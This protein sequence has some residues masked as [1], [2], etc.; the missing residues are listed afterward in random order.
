M[1]VRSILSL[2][3][4]AV[5]AVMGTPVANNGNTKSVG[6]GSD[7]TVTVTA[8]PVTVTVTA[9]ASC[10]A[11]TSH[12][13]STSFST[14]TTHTSSASGSPSTGPSSAS[15]CSTVSGLPSTTVYPTTS[16]TGM[17]QAAEKAGRY[18]GTAADI[19]GTGEA[20]DPYYIAEFN[21][22]A[23]F[24]Q[25]TPANIMKWMYVEP[26]QNVFNFTGGDYFIAQAKGKKIRCHNLN[27]YNQNPYWLTN[28]TT[29][30]NKTGLLAVLENHIDKTMQHF[31]NNCYHWDVVNEAFNDDGTWREDIW[32]NVTGTDYIY[33]A[34]RAANAAKAKYGINSLLFYNDYNI[35]YNGAKAQAAQ[36][37]IR[38]LTAAGIN[39]DG[40]GLQSH[41]IVGQ[42]PGLSSQ[43]QNMQNFANIKNAQGHNI[44]VAVTELD[45]RTTT[46]ATAANQQQQVTDYYNTVNACANV[47]RC[48]GVTV[49]DFDDTYS[50]VPSTFAGQG[51]ADLFFQPCGANTPLVKK[52]A[53]DGVIDGFLNKTLGTYA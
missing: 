28:P 19:P 26:E 38:N 51:Y 42:T 35:E 23:D 46:P 29:P 32:Y 52:A 50:W 45:V 5:P 1:S 17:A 53:I 27:W 30:W 47:A 25:A 33:T 13:T 10:S 21:N 20:Q 39:V 37:L 9:Q 34:F 15:A 2:G 22:N 14:S 44:S 8:A 7:K 48:V 11:S 36:A 4:M 6:N 41:F 16:G 12:S 40:A 43:M 24:D 49:W 18:F 3:L 31:G